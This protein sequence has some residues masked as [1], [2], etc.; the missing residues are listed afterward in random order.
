MRTTSVT[1]RPPGEAGIRA[2]LRQ[3][4]GMARAAVLDPELVFL[5]RRIIS[6]ASRFDPRGQVRRIRDYVEGVTR[7]LPDPVGVE[8]LAGPAVL[9]REIDDHRRVGADCDDVAMLAAA[10][11]NA[12]G[13]RSRLVAVAFDP[14]GPYQHVFTEAWDG[15]EWRELDTT[16][17]PRN[18]RTIR[19]ALTL[20]V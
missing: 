10:L 1:Y 19:R 8:Y 2:T 3:M 20:E 5:A 18:A 6:P 17:P 11:L 7:W 13:I 9:L 4:A 14:E 16:K 12:V 15:A